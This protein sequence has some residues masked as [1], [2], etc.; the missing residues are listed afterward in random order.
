MRNR[1]WSAEG[2]LRSAF[3]IPQRGTPSSRGGASR[4]SWLAL[5]SLALVCLL[6]CGCATVRTAAEGEVALEDV[7]ADLGAVL[8]EV[9]GAPSDAAALAPAPRAFASTKDLKFG[10]CTLGKGSTITLDSRGQATLEFRV[11]SQSK[12]KEIHTILSAYHVNGQFLF[13]HP[14]Q[15]PGW[16]TRVF[17]KTGPK[18]KWHA[19]KRTFAYAPELF[20]AIKEF[21]FSLWCG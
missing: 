1:S 10:N 17:T 13:H 16:L 11:K 8:A 19:W 2:L 5:V 12:N 3:A 9:E 6:G 15:T 4:S 7:D 14:H 21:K 18:N 20:L